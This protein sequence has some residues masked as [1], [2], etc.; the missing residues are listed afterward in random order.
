M[1]EYT[2]S[3]YLLGEFKAFFKFTMRVINV[4]FNRRPFLKLQAKQ[5]CYF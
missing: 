2:M 5:A 4:D 1:V 3:F